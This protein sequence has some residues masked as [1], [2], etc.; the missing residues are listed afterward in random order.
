MKDRS[1]DD[2]TLEM[3][4]KAKCDNVS[5]VFD[6]SDKQEPRC[7]FGD[8]GVC[9]QQCYMGPCRIDPFG[10]GAQYGSCGL[11]ANGIVARNIARDTAVG[12][13]AHSD[14][15]RDVAHNLYMTA[16]GK[17]QGYEIKDAQ[18]LTAIAQEL[19]LDTSSGDINK[20]AAEVAHKCYDLFGQQE[21]EL[22]FAQRAP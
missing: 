1:V 17:T 6:R 21:G 8:L 4:E 3:L 11:D 12:A 18:K 9:C 10:K 7:G 5:T 22:P 2:A 20:I 15:G 19:G 14:H 16:Q 13:S